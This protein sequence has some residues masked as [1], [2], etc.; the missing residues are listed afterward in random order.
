MYFAISTKINRGGGTGG[1]GAAGETQ[2][3][4]RGISLLP[5]HD[6][7]KAA[8]VLCSFWT[9]KRKRVANSLGAEWNQREKEEVL[10][11]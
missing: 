6:E 10:S 5:T 7:F 1:A 11:V 3:V 9:S 8:L 4:L 2:A